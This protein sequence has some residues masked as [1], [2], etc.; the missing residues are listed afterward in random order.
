[1]IWGNRNNLGRPPPGPVKINEAS[2][3]ADGLMAWYSAGASVGSS[4]WRAIPSVSRRTTPSDFALTGG[5]TSGITAGGPTFSLVDQGDVFRFAA[6][7]SPSKALKIANIDAFSMVVWGNFSRSV[8]GNAGFWRND[9]TGG[10]NSYFIV[11]SD[12]RPH[13]RWTNTVLSPG[14]GQAMTFG[15]DVQVAYVVQSSQYASWFQNGIQHHTAV[16]SEVANG[17]DIFFIGWQSNDAERIYGDYYEMRFYSRA[18]SPGD[19]WAMHDPATRWDLFEPVYK[20]WPGVAVGA[21]PA[22][23]MP[24]SMDLMYRRRVS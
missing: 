14:G 24:Q 16:H 8:G 21:P 9:W 20:V 19:V 22:D 23:A 6:S 1:M 10:A 5:M 4:S 11:K 2:P 13:I 7:G 3:Q 12:N 15:E 17:F 18:L